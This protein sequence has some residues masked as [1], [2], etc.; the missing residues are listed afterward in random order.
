MFREK[1]VLSLLIFDRSL[2]VTGYIKQSLR[3]PAQ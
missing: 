1:H 2:E 3:L